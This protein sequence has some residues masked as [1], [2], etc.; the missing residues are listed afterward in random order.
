LEGKS[1]GLDKEK[2]RRAKSESS[3]CKLGLKARSNS[4]IQFASNES[5][6]V[7]RNLEVG[8]HLKWAYGAFTLDVKSLL[9]E[10]LVGILG[11]TQC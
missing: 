9:N 2:K 3:R 7:P 4:R 5:K 11:G 6:L 8:P 1:I 10:N